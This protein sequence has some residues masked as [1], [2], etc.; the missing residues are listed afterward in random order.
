M[1]REPAPGAETQW[2]GAGEGAGRDA[3]PLGAQAGDE[4]VVRVERW[5]DRGEGVAHSDGLTVFTPRLIPGEAARIRVVE[6]KP[7][8]ARA[9]PLQVLT[10]AAT[11]VASR[12]PLFGTCGGCALQHVDYEAQLQA[13][14]LQVAE[15][16]ARIGHL[17]VDALHTLPSPL[18]WRYR[19]KAAIPL[20]PALQTGEP[21]RAGFY[22]SG[23]HEV[24]PFVPA[25]GCAIEDERIDA[26]LASFLEIAKE[27]GVEA[28]D[29]KSG[30]GLLRHLVVR[31]APRG[32]RTLAAAVV[33]S[34][35][36]PEAAEAARRLLAR[37]QEL[38][39]FVVSA[40][41]GPG[42]TIW[43]A[44]N[45]TVT[46]VSWLD[47][48]M[49]VEGWGERR[50]RIDARSFYQVNSLQAERLYAEALEQAGLTGTERVWDLY[51]G[52]GS[53]ALFAAARASSVFAV[54]AA[55]AAVAD[56]RRNAVLNGIDNVRWLEGTVE[57]LVPGLLREG[58]PD[59]V[60]LD[61]PRRGME[62]RAL[63]ALAGSGAR[64]IIYVSC[65]P[66]TLARD[67]SELGTRGGYHVE[68]V[69]PVD[70]FPQT[71]HVETVVLMS[72]VK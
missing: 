33:A 45:R 72:R 24:V 51:T 15:A 14:Q 30:H 29:E 68:R 57:E 19:N 70:L 22:R 62:P 69:L 39:G 28:F 9:E 38:V 25:S 65:N 16:L 17:Q 6:R 55:A 8:Y 20:A 56:A 58:K 47:E 44:R 12:C 61:P 31:V 3:A 64:R 1:S 52:I 42:N 50:F 54:E 13:K 46:G 48:T 67:L 34:K 43:G 35:E 27:M 23:S 5:N 49:R 53:L 11:R 4:R 37:H 7:R 66:A 26:T 32:G 10:P 60:L 41:P 63:A 18:I 36:W 71:A 2:D 59:V 21:I 40:H